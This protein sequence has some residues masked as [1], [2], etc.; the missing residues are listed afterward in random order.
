[1]LR[2]T[3]ILLKVILLQFEDGLSN[4]QNNYLNCLKPRVKPP[5]YVSSLLSLLET[6]GR[7]TLDLQHLF[8]EATSHRAFNL[9]LLAKLRTCIT[10]L[11]TLTMCTIHVNKGS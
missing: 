9:F 8:L 3:K 7:N 11:S 6:M 10:F 4:E 2:K 1:M 5:N